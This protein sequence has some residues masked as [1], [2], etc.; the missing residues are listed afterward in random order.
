[1]I[2]AT[3]TLAVCDYRPE[4][5][6]LMIAEL[7]A[8]YVQEPDAVPAERPL[9]FIVTYAPDDKPSHHF[10]S[11]FMPNNHLR[12]LSDRLEAFRHGAFIAINCQTIE[13]LLLDPEDGIITPNIVAQSTR[14]KISLV[15]SA[16]LAFGCR[17]PERVNTGPKPWVWLRTY[18]CT[19]ED[20]VVKIARVATLDDL[21]CV[22]TV[23]LREDYEVPSWKGTPL[24]SVIGG[25]LCHICPSTPVIYWDE[26][27]H[28]CLR[29]WLA[30]LESAGV[31]L[32]AYGKRELLVLHDA[33]NDVKGAF[34]ADAIARSRTLSRRRIRKDPLPTWGVRRR[35]RKKLARDDFEGGEKYWMPFRI[36]DL[37]IGPNPEDWKLKWVVEYESMA[38]Q[39]WR[40]IENEEEVVMPGAWVD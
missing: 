17:Y 32:L 39:F 22:E 29:K 20:L 6:F 28:G 26:F 25:T 19:W 7:F 9:D 35:E 11:L 38:G 5:K 18:A 36:I 3:K 40:T 21:T 34:D 16:A 1:M 2:I 27:F 30:L 12:P 31:D 14:E 15:H 10:R 4:K 37:E 24:L 33:E 13:N 23:V 8:S